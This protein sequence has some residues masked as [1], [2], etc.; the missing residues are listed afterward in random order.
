VFQDTFDPEEWS[1]VYDPTKSQAAHFAFR[2]G[3]ELAARTC[4]EMAKPGEFWV[5]IGSG[6]GDLAAK[7]VSHGLRVTGIDHDSRMIE[8]ASRRFADRTASGNLQFL[9]SAAV[10]LPFEE[11]SVDGIIATS[12]MGCLD[13]PQP[14]YREAFR[15]L[16]PEGK[17]ILTFTNRSS[18]LLRINAMLRRAKGGESYH[19]YIGR[20]TKEDL[21]RH[22]FQ[23]ESLLYY[24]FFLNPGKRIYP[25]VRLALLAER[26]GQIG[27]SKLFARNFLIVGIKM[28]RRPFS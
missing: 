20:E 22:G 28:I 15:I 12:F 2:H 10:Q 7:L 1:A 21:Q 8:T 17:M 16:K 24:N 11:N 14:F 27:F 25:S 5:D 4:L 26:I 3:T 19:L 23:V 13:S 6:T 9:K 18:L